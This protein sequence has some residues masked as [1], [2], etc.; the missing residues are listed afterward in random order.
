[1][2]AK[3]R[4]IAWLLFL[5]CSILFLAAGLRDRDW[6]M[7]GGS[8]LFLVAVIIFLVVPER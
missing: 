3:M 1:M 6:L 4:L 5:L 7:V 8:A 2:A